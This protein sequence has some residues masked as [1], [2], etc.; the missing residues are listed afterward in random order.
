MRKIF[1]LA[2]VLSVVLANVAAAADIKSHPRLAVMNF[3]NKAITSEG[4]QIGLQGFTSTTL[5][6]TID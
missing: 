2:A 1:L 6:L 5:I 3:A 4:F